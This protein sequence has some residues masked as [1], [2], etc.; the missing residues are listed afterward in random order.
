MR[1]RSRLLPSIQLELLRLFVAGVPARVAAEV[2]GGNRNTAI[3][4]FHKLRQIIA[5]RLAEESP[6]LDGEIEGDERYFGGR[7]KGKRGRGQ[8]ARCPF[9]GCSSA[10]SSRMLFLRVVFVTVAMSRLLLVWAIYPDM[11]DNRSERI[12]FYPDFY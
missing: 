11:Q 7:R 10:A 12:G 8:P 3:L 5:S 9:S 4:F 1:R 6:C 2:T